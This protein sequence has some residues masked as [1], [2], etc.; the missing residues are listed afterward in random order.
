MSEL[1]KVTTLLRESK[2]VGADFA[3]RLN[4]LDEHFVCS[5][6]D[7]MT[8]WNLGRRQQL[9]AHRHVHHALDNLVDRGPLVVHGHH[10]R[11]QRRL[12]PR[13]HAVLAVDRRFGRRGR[14]VHTR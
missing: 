5:M 11:Q 7:V 3:Q 2:S 1:S 6:A 14:A 9:D 13:P 8:L 10:H 12:D 4:R